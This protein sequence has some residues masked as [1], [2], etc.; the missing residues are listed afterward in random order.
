MFYKEF[1]LSLF[2]NM[3]NGSPSHRIKR[4][5]LLH[6]TF[7][8]FPSLVPSIHHSK[9]TTISFHTETIV[10]NILPHLASLALLKLLFPPSDTYFQTT[11][12]ILPNQNPIQSLTAQIPLLSKNVSNP[13]PWWTKLS[14]CC[15]PTLPLFQHL[16]VIFKCKKLSLWASHPSVG[17]LPQ[18]N[19]GNQLW[20][21]SRGTWMCLTG[22]FLV[23]Q[24]LYLG[25]NVYLPRFKLQ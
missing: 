9:C 25:Y 16:S 3:F 21:A 11:I 15:V 13:L 18:A 20:T 19:T 1:I 4:L 10:R 2:S 6:I 14:Q 17:P 23:L 5:K 24:K 22:P 7:K 12:H 8:V